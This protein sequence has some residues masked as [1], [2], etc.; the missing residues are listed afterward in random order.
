MLFLRARNALF[1]V[2]R[3]QFLRFGYLHWVGEPYTTEKVEEAE[4]VAQAMG[5]VLLQKDASE[6]NKQKGKEEAKRRWNKSGRV[7]AWGCDWFY[8]SFLHLA[9]CHIL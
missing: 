2:L 1:H 7:P 9:T 5:A 4:R 3:L 8:V 6:F